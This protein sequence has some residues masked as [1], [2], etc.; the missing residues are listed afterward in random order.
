[1]FVSVAMW[2][3]VAISLERFFAICRPLSSRRWQTQFH[4][5][6]I[7]ALVWFLSFVCHVHRLQPVHQWRTTG[8]NLNTTFDDDDDD[9]S[10]QQPVMCREMWPNKSFE[11]AY[12]MFLGTGLLCF[13]LLT[14]VFAHSMIV[15][16]LWRGFESEICQTNENQTHQNTFVHGTRESHSVSISWSPPPAAFSSGICQPYSP[17]QSSRILHRPWLF[18]PPTPATPVARKH[19][20]RST[21]RSPSS[22]TLPLSPPALVSR[23]RRGNRAAFIIGPCLFRAAIAGHIGSVLASCHGHYRP[24]PSSA[25]FVSHTRSAFTGSIAGGTRPPHSSRICRPPSTVAIGCGL[26]RPQSTAAIVIHNSTVL[27]GRTR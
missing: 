14:M 5:C 27:I 15:S 7:I 12:V 17:R 24:P 18:E 20:L 25:A 16:K 11:K 9:S 6:K 3:L 10:I 23:P 2:T 13:S 21:R 1:V 22:A 4:A 8:T 26:R 19:L